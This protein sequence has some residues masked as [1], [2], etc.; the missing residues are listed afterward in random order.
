MSVATQCTAAFFAAIGSTKPDLPGRTAGHWRLAP[1]SLA[2][3][4]KKK[5]WNHTSKKSLPKR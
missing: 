5:Y 2:G 1:T 4:C 3:H